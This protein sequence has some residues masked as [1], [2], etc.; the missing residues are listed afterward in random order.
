MLTIDY[1]SD[2]L[3]VWAWIAQRRIDEL[4]HQWGDAISWRYHYIDVFGDTATKMQN[5]WADRGLY[6][7]FGEHVQEAAAAYENAPVNPD[8]WSRV[9][10]TTSA[11]AHLIL[12]AVEYSHSREA[13]ES[14]ALAIRAAFFIDAADISDQDTL[15]GIAASNGLDD[16]KI[17]RCIKTGR[18]IAALM[19]DYQLAKNLAIKG[20]PSYILDGGRQALYGNVGY[21]VLNANIAELIKQPTG[22]ASWC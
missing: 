12:K 22:E 4:N 20:S 1:Y 18:G 13:S 15:L 6:Q 9:K 11:N 16:S 17:M 19:S 14:L 10:P 21:R 7:G 3:C 8:I 5:Q 2:V